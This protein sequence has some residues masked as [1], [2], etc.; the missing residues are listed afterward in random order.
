LNITL[1]TVSHRDTLFKYHDYILRLEG[2]EGG[3]SF[4]EFNKKDK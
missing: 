2:E 4:E 3:W 1:F